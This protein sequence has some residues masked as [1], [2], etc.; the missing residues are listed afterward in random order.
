MSAQLELRDQLALG[1]AAWPQH[2]RPL[3]ALVVTSNCIYHVHHLL[4]NMLKRG[5]DH[6]REVGSLVCVLGAAAA[7]IRRREKWLCA[8]TGP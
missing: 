5:P 4:R 3:S 6:C 1:G 8:N 7:K 2:N